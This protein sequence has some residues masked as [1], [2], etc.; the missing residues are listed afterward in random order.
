M[1]KLFVLSVAAAW[2]LQSC[3][4]G[5][6]NSPLTDTQWKL[7]RID[8]RDVPAELAMSVNFLKDGTCT[9]YGACNSGT[10]K[11]KITDKRVNI[12]DMTRTTMACE[13]IQWESEFYMLLG[14]KNDF[15]LDTIA[16]TLVIDNPKSSLHFV[17]AG[18]EADKKHAAAQASAQAFWGLF[19]QPPAGTPIHIPASKDGEDVENPAYAFYGKAVPN[20]HWAAFFAPEEAELFKNGGGAYALFHF[21]F[22][23][24]YV[25]RV[26][27]KYITNSIALYKK[28]SDG[29]LKR[30]E[31]LAWSWGDEGVFNS[32]DAW[33]QDLNNDGLFDILL[34]ENSFEG[35]KQTFDKI[36]A[37][38]QDDSGNFIPDDSIV[39]KAEDGK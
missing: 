6:N 39:P 37:L 16:K 18:S 23:N 29:K 25:L 33:F 15:K 34:R 32:Q 30:I 27:G 22:I 20:E 36:S 12:M 8:N 2:L 11:Y 9:A 21:R 10:G 26:P 7:I 38:R 31:T 17:Q 3:G 4:S 5:N 24:L 13:G 35:K 1:K 28:Q 19:S 14:G